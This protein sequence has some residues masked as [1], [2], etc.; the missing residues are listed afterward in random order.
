MFKINMINKNDNFIDN[1]DFIERDLQIAQLWKKLPYEE[2]L[3]WNQAA[4]NYELKNNQKGISKS[5]KKLYHIYC[6]NYLMNNLSKLIEEIEN[7][8]YSEFKINEN[9]INLLKLIQKQHVTSNDYYEKIKFIIKCFDEADIIDDCIEKKSLLDEIILKKKY[10]SSPSALKN[11]WDSLLISLDL[12]LQEKFKA[13]TKLEKFSISFANR[14]IL[15]LL[16]LIPNVSFLIKDYKEILEYSR[17]GLSLF[18][19]FYFEKL[20]PIINPSE[21][22]QNIM[23]HSKPVLDKWDKI[24]SKELQ[25]YKEKF[26]NQRFGILV[27][28]PLLKVLKTSSYVLHLRNKFYY[29]LLKEKTNNIQEIDEQNDINNN[30]ESINQNE[31]DF[32]KIDSPTLFQD[33]NNEWEIMMKDNSLKTDSAQLNEQINIYNKN[34][35]AKILS[36]TLLFIHKYDKTVK[37]EN[38]NAFQYFIELNYP[39]FEDVLFLL[40]KSRRDV[41]KRN[42]NVSYPVNNNDEDL[43]DSEYFK[44]KELNETFSSSFYDF[45]DF[46]LT[47]LRKLMH[48]KKMI[49]EW[50]LMPQSEKQKYILLKDIIKS[51]VNLQR[52]TSFESKEKRVFFDTLI[53]HKIIDKPGVFYPYNF[54]DVKTVPLEYDI[55]SLYQNRKQNLL[56]LFNKMDDVIDF[57]KNV[58]MK[59]TE[60]VWRKLSIKPH[61]P[62]AYITNL[63]DSKPDSAKLEKFPKFKDYFHSRFPIVYKET[64]ENSGFKNIEDFENIFK[65]LEEG[66][67]LLTK[68]LNQIFDEHVEI[69]ERELTKNYL[70]EDLY[71]SW[72]SSLDFSHTSAQISL[73][74]CYRSTYSYYRNIIHGFEN[75][76]FRYEN[77]CQKALPLEFLKNMKQ[78]VRKINS[79]DINPSE[80]S[81]KLFRELVHWRNLYQLKKNN[82]KVLYASPPAPKLFY[83][84]ANKPNHQI[85]KVISKFPDENI[86][87]LVN[88]ILHNAYMYYYRHG[89]S[90]S[91]A[92]Y[93]EESENCQ[94]NI[95]EID[96]NCYLEMQQMIQQKRYE[97]V[98]QLM[99]TKP[100]ASVLDCE[101]DKTELNA[102]ISKIKSKYDEVVIAKA[103]KKKIDICK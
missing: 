65:S 21:Y 86:N 72:E 78:N 71:K 48:L 8:E 16:P 95:H 38:L 17:V 42:R 14:Q 100:D 94:T 68:M 27:S 33:I 3:K 24:D 15:N 59:Y 26:K 103:N 57:K 32:K 92:K 67:S 82:G 50:K 64:F 1:E 12:I 84:R 83:L 9:Q 5:E 39:Y 102:I 99:E 2:K 77:Y 52:T 45:Y 98:K 28:T 47:N 37:L 79:I 87:K 29:L 20:K 25:I 36:N 44:S 6:K 22:F 34:E 73:P 81:S 70:D 53:T 66:T 58:F 90:D 96:F 88:R 18:E 56:K 60:D 69:Y 41:L 75:A 85:I 46:Q 35:E 43:K 54:K 80:K 51:Q 11:D 49:T 63:L 62:L 91:W 19:I 55:I 101:L 7:K 97:K 40:L 13:L 30:N 23:N 4:E 61:E 74:M 10:Y 31:E 89:Q 76:I 93:R